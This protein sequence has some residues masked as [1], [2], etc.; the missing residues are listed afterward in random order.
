MEKNIYMTPAM[1][2]VN[3]DMD[4]SIM[5]LS[6]DLDDTQYGGDA[7]TS[8]ENG[9]IDADSKERNGWDGGLW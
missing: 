4:N 3:V 8:T 1:E 7:G 9:S 5:Q 2:V 6:G